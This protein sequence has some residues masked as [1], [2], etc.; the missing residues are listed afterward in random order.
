MRAHVDVWRAEAYVTIP[1]RQLAALLDLANVS[2]PT[3][4]RVKDGPISV[5]WDASANDVTVT[6]ARGSCYHSQTFNADE[7]APLCRAL[8][9]MRERLRDGQG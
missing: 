7:I 9:A 6:A 4:I 5:A 3:E 1:P 8:G 2:D